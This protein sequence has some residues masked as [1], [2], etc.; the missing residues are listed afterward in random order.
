M[1]MVMKYYTRT[2]V[3]IYDFGDS[4][5]SHLWIHTLAKL[6]GKSQF[7]L[8]DGNHSLEDEC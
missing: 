6:F 4:G 5:F 2:D 3:I 7:S 8:G 1:E